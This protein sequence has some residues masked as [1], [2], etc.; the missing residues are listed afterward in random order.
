MYLQSL[1]RKCS[2]DNS[3]H[4]NNNENDLF[5]QLN[6]CPCKNSYVYASNVMTCKKIFNALHINC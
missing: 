3:K 1:L 4:K 5:K 2:V 6:L